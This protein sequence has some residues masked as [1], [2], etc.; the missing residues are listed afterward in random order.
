MAEGT[1]TDN[2]GEMPEWTNQVELHP[3]NDSLRS[4][5]VAAEAAWSDDKDRD[6]DSTERMSR[7]KQVLAEVSSRLAAI[8]TSLVQLQALNNLNQPIRRESMSCWQ[9][10]SPLAMRVTSRQP[11]MSSRTFWFISTNGACREH[12]SGH[13][14]IRRSRQS[15]GLGA[16]WGRTFGNW[17]LRLPK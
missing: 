14:G 7:I 4:A 11:T 3:V 2:R 10:I 13:K 15:L 17:N 6:P 5:S 8:D 12:G 1:A 16:L 9:R